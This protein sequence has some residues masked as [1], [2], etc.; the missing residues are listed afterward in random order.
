MRLAL[1][2]RQWLLAGEAGASRLRNGVGT[3][4]NW[5]WVAATVNGLSRNWRRYCVGE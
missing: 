1:V 2:D 4:W 5:L 3:V